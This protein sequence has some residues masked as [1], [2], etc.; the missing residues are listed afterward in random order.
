MPLWPIGAGLGLT[1]I[2]YGVAKSKGAWSGPEAEEPEDEDP[3]SL[4][5]QRNRRRFKIAGVSAAVGFG[6]VYGGLWVAGTAGPFAAKVYRDSGG[7]LQRVA[8]SQ[9]GYV[10]VRTGARTIRW[11]PATGKG[12]LK[13][14]EVLNFRGGSYTETV[15]D[16]PILLY[17]VYGGNAAQLRSYW[18]RV[19]PTGPLQSRLDSA[20][21]HKWG[22]TAEKVAVIRLPARTTFYE[23]FAAPQGNLL[24]GGNQVFVPIVK[25][26][27]VVK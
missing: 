9:T 8:T 26:E 20:L 23:G 13:P 22:N 14:D 10:G 7:S 18:T 1:A 27:W 2:G 17:R 11:G 16:E 12:P 21:L 24:G 4:R 15:L 19:P 25:P 6:I 3:D 5:I